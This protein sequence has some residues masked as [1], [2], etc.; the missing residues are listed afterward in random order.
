MAR[1][2]VEGLKDLGKALEEGSKDFLLMLLRKALGDVME[3]D[4]T[5]ICQAQAGERS[6]LRENSRNG[7]RERDLETRMGTV[8]LKIPK[9]RQ[10]SYFPGF[11]EP[12][13]AW[14]HAFVN[15][16]AEAYVSGVSTRKVEK[17]VEAMG[18]KGMSKSEVSRMAQVLDADVTVF[19]ERPLEG[20]FRYIYLDAMYPKVR[21]GLRVIGLAVL[22]AIGVN[23]DGR[24]EVLGLEVAEGEM[25]ACWVGFLEGL[26]RRGLAGV[27]LTISDAHTGLKAGVRRVLN[28]VSWQRCRVHFMRNAAGKLTRASQPKYLGRLKEAFQ[29]PTQEKAKAAFKVLADESRKKHPGFAALLDDAADDVL[30]FMA[31]PQ[32]HWRRIHSTNVLERENRELRRRSDV[33][34]IFPNRGA[35]LRLLGTILADQHAEW[36]SARLPYLRDP[37]K[38][39]EAVAENELEEPADDLPELSA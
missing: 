23:Q 24:R 16:V 13:K 6:P 20:A 14:E 9:L 19:R 35:V 7:Y 33:V 22:V 11:L 25:E 15:V 3:A 12:R 5:D 28:G 38:V 34:G 4:V 17:L 39:D 37:Q 10:G 1:E 30:A 29:E 18:A 32:D 31:F 21:E 2:S 8:D 36:C 27:E 26:V